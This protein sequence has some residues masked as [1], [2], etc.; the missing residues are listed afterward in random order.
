MSKLNYV[1]SISPMVGAAKQLASGSVGNISTGPKVTGE[2]HWP[3]FNPP[4]RVPDKGWFGVHKGWRPTTEEEQM[5]YARQWLEREQN[6]ESPYR[7]EAQALLDSG[8]KLEEDMPKKAWWQFN[9]GGDVTVKNPMAMELQSAKYRP[10]K[11]K[12]R[13]G[14][15]SYSRKGR[16][17]DKGGM[18]PELAEGTTPPLYR[19]GGGKLG[20]LDYIFGYGKTIGPDHPDYER[21]SGRGPREPGWA[22]KNIERQLSGD[23]GR[24]K[25]MRDGVLVYTDTGEPVQH[26][27]IGGWISSLFGG[28]DEA[29]N[30]KEIA[31]QYTERFL[32]EKYQQGVPDYKDPY[33]GFRFN[34]DGSVVSPDGMTYSHDEWLKYKAENPPQYKAGGGLLDDAL[35]GLAN[36]RQ[37]NLDRIRAQKIEGAADGAR[38][39]RFSHVRTR[40]PRVTGGE[41]EAL[42]AAK[43]A[44][45][46]RPVPSSSSI[47]KPPTVEGAKR[48]ADTV[49]DFV[50]GVGEAKDIY[51]AGK[52]LSQ[53]NY[54]EAALHGGA[55]AVGLIPGAGDAAAAG[56]RGAGRNLRSA[57]TSGVRNFHGF[58]RAS[59]RIP[60][61][62]PDQSTWN[63]INTMAQ[64]GENIHIGDITR[65]DKQG[66]GGA[67]DT[68]PGQEARNAAVEID[69]KMVPVVVVPHKDPNKKWH[70][71][72]VRDQ[73]RD[74]KQTG[75]LG[76][77]EYESGGPVKKSRSGNTPGSARAWWNY[78]MKNNNLRKG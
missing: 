11:I 7:A 28:G 45:G 48:A 54:G 38:P 5:D 72:T 19:E 31:D 29:I 42:A 73:G 59:E 69:G 14:K 77:R 65:R 6:L 32:K 37:A 49:T 44:A 56:I 10:K 53:G 51:R 2:K 4:T 61:L 12:P 58:E 15:G 27:S 43:Q 22:K 24:Q 9:T 21:I 71:I 25:S 30:E 13:K 60:H 67:K 3:G 66:K 33:E 8:L 75:V 74:G 17:Y 52:A 46:G 36:L 39:S 35:G 70:I 41:A 1:A 16:H 20:W 57:A 23:P 63:N 62:V 47:P 68:R 18:I 78:V 26:K 55:A 40:A 64:R 50:P 34:A 76:G